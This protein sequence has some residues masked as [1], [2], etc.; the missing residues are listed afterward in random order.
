VPF[1]VRTF[2]TGKKAGA[3]ENPALKSHKFKTNTSENKSDLQ[4]Y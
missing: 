2:L 4:T 1:P 3:T